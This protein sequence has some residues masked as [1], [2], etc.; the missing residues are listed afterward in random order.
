[1]FMAI[2][3]EFNINLKGRDFI[4]LHDF[5]ADEIYYLLHVAESLKGQNPWDDLY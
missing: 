2:A 3:K 4:S 1:M 5:T